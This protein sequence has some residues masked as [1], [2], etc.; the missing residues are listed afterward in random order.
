[1][2][3]CRFIL[4]VRRPS[5]PPGPLA[6]VVPPLLTGHGGFS[7]P[8]LL[9]G[10]FMLWNCYSMRLILHRGS[11]VLALLTLTLFWGGGTPAHCETSNILGLHPLNASSSPHTHPFLHSWQLQISWHCKCPLGQ[12]CFWFRGSYLENSDLLEKE[13]NLVRM[14]FKYF[15]VKDLFLLIVGIRMGCH[16]C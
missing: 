9:W 2:E 3:S 12:H 15:W 10:W 6:E 13:N 14:F 4:G 7:I 16:G 1:V 5:V 11:S 8:K